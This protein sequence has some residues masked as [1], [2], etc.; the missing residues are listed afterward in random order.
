MNQKPNSTKSRN[1]GQSLIDFCRRGIGILASRWR[2]T[3]GLKTQMYFGTITL[4]VVVALLAVAGIQGVLKFRALTKDIRHRATELPLTAEL[5]QNVSDLRVSFTQLQNFEEKH[6]EFGNGFRKDR[7]WLLDEFKSDVENTM[8]SLEKYEHQLETSREL[9]SSIADITQELETVGRL[10]SKLNDIKTISRDSN[11]VFHYS[12]EDEEV[13]YLL[14]EIQFE[15][16]QLPTF[17]K[18]RMDTFAET[19]RSKYHAWFAIS[20]VLVSI[21]FVLIVSLWL[22]FRKWIF[23]P[24]QKLIAGSRQVASGNYDYRI[25]LGTRDE[26]AELAD[27]LNDMTSNFQEIQRELNDQVRQRTKEVVRSE[28]M[29]S[30]GFLAAGVAHEIN[31][32]LAAIAWSAESLEMRL[33]DILADQSGEHSG[34][35]S[36]DQDVSEMKRYLRRIQD[37]AFRCKGITGSLL[38]FSRLGEASRQS[39]D[40]VELVQGVIDM[41][42]PLSKYRRKNLEF[43]HD[44]QVVA[45]VI[46]QEIKQVVLN[47][48]TN[49]LDSVD[50]E[51]NVSLSLRSRNGQVELSVQDDGCGMTEEVIEHL[52]EPFFTRRPNGKGTG[53]GLSITYRIIDEHGGSIVPSSEGPQ[54]GSRF[55]VRIPI[56]KPETKKT[57]A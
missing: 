36:E 54:R 19:A 23:K 9:D 34:E 55:V 56:Q 16:K 2:Q 52:F 50:D 38:D 4:A 8:A 44:K 47:L 53:L 3:W 57:A 10:K 29:A 33:Q 17:M 21:A 46:A 51:G 27:A 13:A 30:V 37:E 1:R 31:N 48:L 12:G 26:V 5:N 32:P 18:Q 14:D 22:L 24:L 35:A 6:N 11:M 49:A 39:T 40:L 41:V 28:Q 25:Q 7:L 45:N 20:L 43:H 15:V 42:R